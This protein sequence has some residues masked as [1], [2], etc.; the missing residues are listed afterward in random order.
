MAGC[1]PREV[2]VFDPR[3]CPPVKEYSK[4]EQAQA[5]KAL[6]ETP[7]IIQRWIVDYG[8][9]RDKSRACKKPR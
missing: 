8:K 3:A 9:L 7:P 6:D 5:A 2:G 4:Q 1:A